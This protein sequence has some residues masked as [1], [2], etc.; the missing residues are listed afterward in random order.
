V[1][2]GG[3]WEKGKVDKVDTMKRERMP[4]KWS[5]LSEYEY[6]PEMSLTSKLLS[7]KNFVLSFV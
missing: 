1:H 4:G 3:R 6:T 2:E 7:P 5:G